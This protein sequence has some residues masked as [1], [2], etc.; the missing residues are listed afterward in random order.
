MPSLAVVCSG[1]GAQRPDMFE[2]LLEHPKAMKLYRLTIDSEALPK[3][4]AFALESKSLSEELLRRNDLAQPAI[5]LYQMLVWEILKPL[6]HEVELFA[7]YSLGE[8]SAYGCAGF[9]APLETARLATQRGRLMTDAAKV[10][11]TM[12]AVIGL[13]K[14]RLDGICAGADAQ[15]AIRNG[16]D[17]FVVGL[18]AGNLDLF[19]SRCMAAGAAKTV[20]LP[21]SVASHTFYMKE[22][23]ES[24]GKVLEEADI[25]QSGAG[26]LAGMDGCKVF[27]KDQALAV[28][29]KQI[30][31]PID[32]MA[33]MESAISYG[34][35][36]FLELGP[37]DSLSRMLMNGFQGLQAR[38]VSEFHDI[39][40]AGRWAAAHLA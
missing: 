9:L 5:C 17:H 13:R 12:I 27:S 1:Q 10:P 15:I 19:A 3:E 16:S 14:E 22:A 11:Q 32:W 25:G 18:P 38:S 4:L 29:T 39:K 20:H 31:S 26:I 8:L 7:G 36:V 23:A 21:V 6:L 33:C 37:G 28:L 34:C 35:D 30:H 2:P 40:A 24:F